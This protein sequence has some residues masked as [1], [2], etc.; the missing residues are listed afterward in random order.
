MANEALVSLMINKGWANPYTSPN[1]QLQASI[2]QSQQLQ[3]LQQL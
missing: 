1:D 3:Q 2:Q